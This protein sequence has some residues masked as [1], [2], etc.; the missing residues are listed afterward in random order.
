MVATTI[1]IKIHT[2]KYRNLFLDIE[3]LM[4]VWQNTSSRCLV[5]DEA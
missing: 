1:G 2:P 3:K 4:N 5:I